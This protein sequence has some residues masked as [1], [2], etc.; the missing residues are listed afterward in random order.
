MHDS[1]PPG[2]HPDSTPGSE[3][4]QDVITGHCAVIAPVRSLRPGGRAASTAL[5]PS[6]D[7]FATGNESETPSELFAC[8]HTDSSP[9]Q[10]GWLLRVVPNRFPAVTGI[11]RAQTPG[12]NDAPPVSRDRSSLTHS[13]PFQGTHDVVVECADQRSQWSDFDASEIA[14]VLEAWQ[15]RTRQLRNHPSIMGVCIFRNEGPLAGASLRHSHS[16]IVGYTT[17]PQQIAD[18]RERL[19]SFRKET[20]A[21][22]VETV[23]TSETQNGTRIIFESDRFTVTAAFAPLSSGHL[24]ILPLPHVVRPF[25]DCD[26]E[27]R[28]DLAVILKA[29]A[30]VVQ[31]VFGHAT[32]YNVLLQ[33]DVFGSPESAWFVDIVPRTSRRAGWELL[34]HIDIVSSLPE[35]FADRCRSAWPAYTHCSQSLPTGYAWT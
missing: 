28:C 17:V 11:D 32:S 21:D 1:Q 29:A 20:G 2:D 23:R 35:E 14:I 26:A 4:R 9:D 13:F 27:T 33:Q 8:R 16:Q 30:C 5:S 6:R 31:D 25:D 10:P 24:R 12:T 3:M 22:L 7:P 18:R 19:R 15:R 34:T